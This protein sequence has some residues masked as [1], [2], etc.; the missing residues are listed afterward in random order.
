VKPSACPDCFQ[1]N[2]KDRLL[3]GALCHYF[4]SKTDLAICKFI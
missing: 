2:I 3:Y 4:I 1:D